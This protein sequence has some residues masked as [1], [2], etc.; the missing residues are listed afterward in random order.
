MFEDKNTIMTETLNFNP[1]PPPFLH[2]FYKANLVNTYS[3]LEKSF[4]SPKIFAFFREIVA[5]FFIA[6]LR[7]IFYF[8][9][10]NRE[11]NVKFCKKVS[12]MR[13]KNFCEI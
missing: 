9:L 5:Y 11:I 13:K 3:E 8:F 6:K 1:D 4:G 10:Q 7:I 12:E 2:F